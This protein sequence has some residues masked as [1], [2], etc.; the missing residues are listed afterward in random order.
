[1]T[2][3][4]K[5]SFVILAG[6]VL[7]LTVV[8][9]AARRLTLHQA[10]TVPVVAESKSTL[11]IAKDPV[12]APLAPAKPPT[13]PTAPAGPIGPVDR[14]VIAG[15]GGR[16][17]GANFTV[18]ATIGEPIASNTQSGGAFAVVGG[19]WSGQTKA[20]QTINFAALANKTLGDAPFAVNATGGASGMQSPS[21][22]QR[23]RYAQYRDAS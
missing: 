14:S 9:A 10:D 11:R 1:M 3:L 5:K 17:T 16:T 20:N 21:V 15:G 7:A 4:R 19:Y 6:T 13:A 12:I 2:S 23:R 8:A 22:L 18:E